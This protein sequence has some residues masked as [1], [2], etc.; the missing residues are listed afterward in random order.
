MF[1]NPVRP[2]VA[3]LLF[4]TGALITLLVVRSFPYLPAP[5]WR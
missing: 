2:K 4:T 1:R 3:A 5:P